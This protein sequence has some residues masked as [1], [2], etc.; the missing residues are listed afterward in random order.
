[1]SISKDDINNFNCLFSS[2]KETEYKF[3][4]EFTSGGTNSENKTP[5]IKSYV[6]CIITQP[7]I[8]NPLINELNPTGT[9]NGWCA[10]IYDSI[11]I[12]VSYDVNI[13]SILD[14]KI[15]NTSD[16]INPLLKQFYMANEGEGDLYVNHL[17]AVLYL[18]NKLNDTCDETETENE[19]SC[20]CGNIQSAIWTLLSCPV[21]FP[22]SGFIKND[23]S[24]SVTSIGDVLGLI[25]NALQNE[26]MY[27]LEDIPLL[28][29]HPVMC[30]FLVPTTNQ[31]SSFHQIIL[32]QC[33]LDQITTK[34]SSGGDPHIQTLSGE[35]YLLN[36]DIKFINLLSDVENQIFINAQCD[37]I[38][39]NNFE[40]FIYCK[41]RIKHK[42][43]IP[44]LTNFTYFRKLYIKYKEEH[45]TLNMDDLFV[46]NQHNVKNIKINQT[47]SD[48]L[49][50]IVHNK[51][52][53][54]NDTTRKISVNISNKIILYVT[55]DIKTDERHFIN[56]F[57]NH[58]KENL[59]GAMI[60]NSLKNK[61]NSL[62]EVKN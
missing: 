57:V 38:A 60:E 40:K 49:F 30:A 25:N 28:F 62:T 59:S 55:S 1:M 9:Y 7:N 45:L 61:I 50:S 47:N 33:Q 43:K 27:S 23:S 37:K 21:E 10:D 20:K 14:P 48:G 4:I 8:D 16:E 17:G 32:L 18:V 58:A 15:L 12:G 44:S 41:D 42:K 34:C 46:Y 53:P 31:I 26:E 5:N 56:L 35:K 52:Y 54:K 36:D 51:L 29:E 22:Y 19:N 13:Y 11:G 6:N 2:D 39:L 3:N 24:V